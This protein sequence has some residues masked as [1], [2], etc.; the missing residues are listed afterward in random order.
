[1]V[2]KAKGKVMKIFFRNPDVDTEKVRE[3]IED[4]VGVQIVAIDE[5]EFNLEERYYED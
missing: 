1:M 3:A 2:H 4:N 5:D